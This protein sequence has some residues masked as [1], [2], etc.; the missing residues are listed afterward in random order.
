MIDPHVHCRDG[1]QAY[2]DTISHVLE[3][4]QA[5]GVERVFDMPNT[6]PPILTPRDVRK[7]LKLVPRRKRDMYGL[8]V[9]L[10]SSPR[11]VKQAFKAWRKNKHVMGMK[12]YAGRSVGDLAVVK[13]TEQLMVYRTLADLDYRGVLMVHCAKQSLMKPGLWDPDQPWTHAQ[14]RPKASE[15]ESV[16]D[17]IKFA[18]KAGF[19]GNLHVCH[20][21]CP[22]SVKLVNQAQGDLQITCGVTPHHAMWTTKMMRRPDGLLYKMNPPL[23]DTASVRRLQSMLAKG[24]VTWIE[25]DHAPH[26]IGEKLFYPHSSGFPSL[27]LY[28]DFVEHFLPSLGLDAKLIKRMTSENIREVFGSKLD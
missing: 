23:R 1:S 8:H 7:R 11:Q 21:S 3:V 18:R 28:R 13:P 17:Q 6:N 16:R 10:T 2:K 15:V 9:G 14:V 12:L 4:A 19:K 26:P 20:T 24:M 27:Y 22:E 25:T 5:Q